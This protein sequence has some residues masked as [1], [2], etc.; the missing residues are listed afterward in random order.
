MRVLITGGAGF[1]GTHLARRLLREACEVT[2]LDNFN[3]QVHAGAVGLPDDLGAHVRLVRGDIRDREIVR[4]ALEGQEVVVHYAAETG[5]GQ[6]MYEI[7]RYEAVN[8]G[9]TACLLDVLVNAPE[10]PVRKLVV[11]S[12]R[13][14]YGEGKYACG[15]HGEVFPRKRDEADL[16]AGHFEP[17]C[18]QCGRDVEVAATDE[19]SRIEPASFY[20]LTKHSQE[21]MTLLFARVLGIDGFALRY[22]NVFGPGQSLANPYTGILA[23][24]SS[25]AKLGQPIELFEDGEE[26]RDFV[27]IDDV[28]EGT[29]RCIQAQTKGVEV[30]NIGSGQ[31]VSVRQV[32]E[33]INAHFGGRS[34]IRVGGG[35]R[36]GDIRH[37]LADL[38]L[39]RKTLGFEPVW[40]FED[41][42][43][44]F[45][46]WAAGQREEGSRYQ[47][48]LAEMRARGLMRG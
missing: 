45:L 22:Q 21:Q 43:R 41:G 40:R 29:W 1:I 24:F 17:R 15:E 33:A 23:V 20:G 2:I 18:P 12:S 10:H 4:D 6:S 48:S 35:Y 3:P 27:Y 42:L 32:A 34:P 8:L 39:V 47:Q 9:G 25:L 30:L 14:V 46:A 13:A 19:S 38:T 28:I 36:L 31:R 16:R 26:S 7:G 5:T 44:A 11:A 37:S